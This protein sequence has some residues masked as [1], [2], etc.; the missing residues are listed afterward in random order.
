MSIP[1]LHHFALL[2][3][4][5]VLVGCSDGARLTTQ[6]AIQIAQ[7]T[8]RHEGWDL[9]DYKPPEAHYEFTRNEFTRKDRSWSVFFDGKIPRP[10]NHLY[11]SI[12]D[13]TGET[14]L[15]TEE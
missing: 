6:E 14:L 13:R 8:A 11:V 10:D 7:Q 15:I 12:D 1:I 2:T 5:A 3:F 9:N 4:A